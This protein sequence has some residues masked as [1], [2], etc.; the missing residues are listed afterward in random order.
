M[1]A[2][3]IAKLEK[4]SEPDRGLF[5]D[6]FDACWADGREHEFWMRF[7]KL[8]EYEAWTDAALTILPEGWHWS[9]KHDRDCAPPNDKAHAIVSLVSWDKRDDEAEFY[10]SS[11]ALHRHP[12]IALCIAAIRARAEQKAARP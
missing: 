8:V 7:S 9:L 6:C 2:E 11:E 5:W 3:L 4:A 1:S 12:A 10:K